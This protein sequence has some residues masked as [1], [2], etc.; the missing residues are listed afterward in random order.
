MECVSWERAPTHT[1][2][3]A[4]CHYYVHAHIHTYTHTHIHTYMRSQET[5]ERTQHGRT[6]ADN[7]QPLRRVCW[8][9]GSRVL[10]T[11]THAP[12]PPTL[13]FSSF[14]F[15]TV[16]VLKLSRRLQPVLRLAKPPLSRPGVWFLLAHASTHTGMAFASAHAGRSLGHVRTNIHQYVYISHSHPPAA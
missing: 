9:L 12:G 16:T 5:H 4:V 1:H 15:G 2:T 6:A 7:A 10:S 3:C 8:G 11:P 14:F 13:A